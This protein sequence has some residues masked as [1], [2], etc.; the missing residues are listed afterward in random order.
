MFDKR[1]HAEAVAQAQYTNHLT[2]FSQVP[3]I[4]EGFLVY[5]AQSLMTMLHVAEKRPSMLRHLAVKTPKPFDLQLDCPA[6]KLFPSA[7]EI[8]DIVHRRKVDRRDRVLT[9]MLMDFYE[10]RYRLGKDVR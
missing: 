9:S 8:C 3:V 7:D 1:T 6:V 2:P 4:Q 5:V 10:Q